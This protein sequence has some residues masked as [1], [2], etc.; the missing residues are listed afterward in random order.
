MATTTSPINR[1]STRMNV[2]SEFDRVMNELAANAALIRSRGADGEANGRPDAEVIK[3]LEEIGAFKVALPEAVGGYEFSPRQLLAFMEELAFH[4]SST[5]WNV[6]GT[7]TAGSASGAFLDDSAVDE[8]FM[9]G[10]V[11]RLTGQGTRQG[12]GRRVEGGYVIS[13]H[14]Q[15]NSGSPVTTHIHTAVLGDDGKSFVATLPI[16]QVRLIDNW[17]VLGLRAT[18]S[19]DYKI[20]EVFV[21]DSFTYDPVNPVQKRGGALYRVGLPNVA[22]L[23]HAGWA[24]GVVKRMLEELRGIARSRKLNDAQFYATYAELEARYR[25]MRSFLMEVWADVEETLDSGR[26]LDTRQISLIHLG[27]ITAKRGAQAIADSAATWSGSAFLRPGT[28]Q[29]YFRDVY[30]GVQHLLCSPPVQQRVGKELSGLADPESFWI[31]YDLI[32]P[33]SVAS[34]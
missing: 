10:T 18:G 6:L 33:S 17:D 22:T 24:L 12:S 19:S 4:E 20:D 14:W 28:L 2:S 5:A 15:F 31:F 30:T 25:G 13:G 3:K 27:T 16:E 26:E 8:Y 34:A 11:A 21:P 29:R 1:V 32:E 23:H 9:Q 7:G